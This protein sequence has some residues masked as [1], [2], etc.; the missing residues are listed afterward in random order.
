MCGWWCVTS[1]LRVA[2]GT[3]EPT[4]GPGWPLS[5]AQPAAGIAY[6]GCDADAITTSLLGFPVAAVKKRSIPAASVYG[7][8]PLIDVVCRPAAAGT[9]PI[10][11]TCA[12]PTACE[13]I[14]ASCFSA[15]DVTAGIE[16]LLDSRI[17][18]PTGGAIRTEAAIAASQSV[19]GASVT[20]RGWVLGV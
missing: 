1:A 15:V 10:P 8:L 5:A 18:A 3:L 7:S 4:N 12:P 11:I 2:A 9:P 19:V 17:G 20:T 16:S 13:P 14:G 6:V